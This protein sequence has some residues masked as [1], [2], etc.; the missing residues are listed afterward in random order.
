MAPD[1]VLFGKTLSLLPG[2]RGLLGDVD[3]EVVQK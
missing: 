1:E 2:Q 3:E